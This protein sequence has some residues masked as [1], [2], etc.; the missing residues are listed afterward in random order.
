MSRPVR[1]GHP[2]S[3]RP[4]G[5]EARAQRIGRTR[6][7][8]RRASHWDASQ[9]VVDVR[10][11]SKT[12]VPSPPMMRVLLRS[13]IKEP[14]DALKNVSLQVGAGEICAIVGPNGAGKSTLFRV[15]SGLTTPTGGSA[16]IQGLNVTTQSFHV[17]QLI[18]FHAADER[19]LLGRHTCAENLKFHG[20]LQ[21]IPEKDLDRRT[22]AA[23]RLVGLERAGGR[24]ALALSSGM[25]ARLQL[26]RALLHRP[27]VLILDE[28]T[29]ALDPVAAYEFLELIKATTREHGIA[30]LL[31]SHRLEEIEALPEHVLLLD[32]GT[33]VFD[34]HLD[35][36]RRVW[37]E[38]RLEVRFFSEATARAASGYLSTIDGVDVVSCNKDLITLRSTLTVGDLFVAANGHLDGV[39]AIGESR[40][41]LRE[42]LAQMLLKPK[43]AI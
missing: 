5:G 37:N 25:K 8:M 14:V 9:P 22:R 27:R 32:G 1:D 38:P 4:V 10:A 31:S 21:G 23:L 41:P 39:V 26:A 36:L 42:L 33:V 30:T 28:P 13:A 7:G 15:L 24:L 6:E 43:D 17:R 29:G 3:L 35:A 20:R 34:G 16:Y 2:G 18:G 40:I 12:Y 19:M 11:L